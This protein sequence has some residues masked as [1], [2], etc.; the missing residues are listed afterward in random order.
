MTEDDY[1]TEDE[2][3]KITTWHPKDFVGCMEYI[4]TLWNYADCGYWK[5]EGEVYYLST[6]GWSGNEDIIEALENN[7]IWWMMYW[8]QSRRGG[9][10]IFAPADKWM[11][12]MGSEPCPE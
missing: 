7:Y 5:Q 2:L 10:Y 6:G 3:H 1:P 4:L 9:H 11:D 12:K 8:C